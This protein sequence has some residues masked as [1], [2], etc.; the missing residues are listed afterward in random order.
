MNLGK[1]LPW[2][3]AAI[4]AACVAAAALW[5]CPTQGP[6][7]LSDV[8]DR[9]GVDFHH[10]DGSGGR[11]YIVET[12]TA[13]LATFDYDGDG[14]ID[15]YFLNGRP[16]EGTPPPAE[17]PKNRLYRNLGGFRFQDVTDQAGV[18][19]AGYGLGVAVGDYN[20]DGLPDLYVSNFGP[21][22]LYRN[23]GDGTFSDVTDAAGVADGFKVG[24]GASFLDMDADG[25]LD[26][27]VANYVDFSYE[28]H[29][30]RVWDG[31]PIY[32]GPVEFAPLRHTLFRN[33][34]NGTFTDVSVESGIAQHPGTGMGMV[35]ADY[36]DD[37]D[38]DVF[39]LND[40]FGNF[41]FQ[42]DGHGRFEE[43]GLRC[44]FK[45]NG[46]GME[47]GSMG[48][49][50]G[51]YDNDGRIDLFQ[52]SYQGELCV[53]FRNLG[54]GTFEDVTT[55]SGAGQGSRNNVKW[56]C[57]L[58][59]FDNDGHRDLFVG[60]GH[61]HDNIEVY[62][63]TSTYEATSVLLRNRGDGT[64]ADVSAEAGTGL[65]VKTVVRGV[66][67]DDLDND[68]RV[69]VAILASRRPALILRNETRTRNHWLQVSL[70]GAR[71]NRDGV[72]ARVRVV[73]GDLELVDEVHSGRGYQSHFG[74]RLHF[75]LGPR[76]RVDRVEVRWLG[77]GTDV[78]ENLPADRHVV[79]VEG[80][81][82]PAL[83]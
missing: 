33:E 28:K 5:L 37:G 4:L 35:C 42:N 18:G 66:A 31:L 23:N 43:V 75:G 29:V 61:L 13:G 69:D 74:S 53:L 60:M 26:L 72:G 56:G 52:T 78:L 58:V 22:K 7:V 9:S 14:W 1:I 41:C 39:V 71:S 30:T 50:A 21:K 12:V 19:E 11:K 63:K 17:P 2:G 70:R 6:I 77:G 55:S 27:Y 64:F 45:F 80:S 15:I 51:D 20:N 82:S 40:V 68:G 36:D 57:A 49:D 25:D 38:T 34:G 67:C 54:D 73:A 16:L 3:G 62:D 44:G 76:P 81:A 10:T 65:R 24:A 59:D 8:T 79:I 83:P 32:P 48:V 46:S 47:L